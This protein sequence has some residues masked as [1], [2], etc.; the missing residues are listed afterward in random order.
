MNKYQ[1]ELIEKCEQYKEGTPFNV[2][3]IIPSGVAFN[4]FGEK[5]GY[6]NIYLVCGTHQGED[7]KFYVVGKE[8][9]I[10]VVQFGDFLTPA[11]TLRCDVPNK[12]NCA[13]FF[14]H[15]R[16]KHFVIKNVASFVAVEVEDDKFD[17]I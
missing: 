10:D 8:H 6:N 1:K 9:Q 11:V 14:C 3:Y 5:N 16:N 2:L 4:A 12:L 15:V 13:R 17:S 7:E